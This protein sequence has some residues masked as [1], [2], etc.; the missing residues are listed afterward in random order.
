MIRNE[1]EYRE[2]VARLAEERQRLAGHRERL[3][4]EKLGAQGIARVLEPIECFHLQLREEVESYER[5][6]QGILD[7][8]HNLHGLGRILIGLR[9]A[10]GISQKD[11]AE[12]LG[13]HESQVSRDERNE[14]HGVTVERATRILDALGA[15]LSSSFQEPVLPFDAELK[16]PA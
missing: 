8:V 13:V 10:R 11:L 7:E 15:D 14:Y 2:A 4:A 12:R 6:R 9:I 3:E 1:T 5:L 16:E